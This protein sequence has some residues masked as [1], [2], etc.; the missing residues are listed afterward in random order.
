MSARPAFLPHPLLSLLLLVAWLWLNDT[1]APGHVLLGAALALAIPRLTRGFWPEPLA[2]RH[3]LMV[4]E[5]L[6]LVSWDIV[7]ANLQVAAL[8]LGPASRLK[9]GHVAV[10]LD[11]RSDFGIT[12]L[13]S[14]VTLT[15]GTVSVSIERDG[16]AAVL[17]VHCLR[18]DSESAIVA[19][20]KNRYEARLREIL[21]C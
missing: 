1:L 9:P 20:I 7:V 17:R 21:E 4:V 12:M 13:A 15:P 14:T 11:L 10:P 18:V 16:D 6:L 5:Y 19:T 2:V 3:P 8:I